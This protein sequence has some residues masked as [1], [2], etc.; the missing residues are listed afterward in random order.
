MIGSRTGPYHILSKIGEGGMGAVY[1]ARDERLGRDVA[2]KVFSPSAGTTETARLRLL[3]EA[4]LASALNHP[5]ICTIYGVEES[6]GQTLIVMEHVIGRRLL[7]VIPPEGLSVA[8]TLRYGAQIADALA[9][10]HGRNVLHRDLKTANVM[11]TAEDRVKVLDFGLAKR[12]EEGA[13]DAATRS[14]LSLTEPGSVVGTLYALAPEVLRGEAASVRSD[15]WALGVVLYEMAAGRPPFSGKTNFELSAAVLREEPSSLEATVP[16][17]LQ[18]VIARCFV[19]EPGRRYQSAAEVRAALEAAQ[20]STSLPIAPQQNSTKIALYLSI[21][22]FAVAASITIL[23]FARPKLHPPLVQYEQLTNFSDSVTSPAL[24]PDGRMLAFLHADSTFN[25]VGEIWVKALPDGEPA[26]VTNDGAH[27]MKPTFSPDGSRIAYSHIEQWNWDTWTV[28]SLGGKTAEKWLPNAS[29]LTWIG[30]QQVLFSEITTGLYMKIVTS[31]ENRGGEHDVYLPNSGEIAMAHSSTLS[32]DGKWVLVTEMDNRGW[33]PCRV[34]P[35]G[36]GP[37]V[38]VVGPSPS[39]CTSA[40][41]S[42]DG[43]SMYFSADNGQGFHLWR[44]EFP[45]GTV[46]QLTSGATEEEG[47]AVAHDGKSLITAIGTERS[48]IFLQDQGALRQITSQGYAYSPTLSPDGTQVY[49]LLRTAAERAFVAGDLRLVNTADGHESRLLPGFS[50]TRYDVSRDGQRIVFAA[51]GPDGKSNIWLAP[52]TRAFAPRQ[53]T[54]GEAYRPYFA[55]GGLIYY[56]R[57]EA[58][59]DYVFRMKED[60]TSQ[61]KVIGDPVIYL[62]A[63]SPDGKQLVTWEDRKQADSPNAVMVHAAA[64]GTEAVL[65]SRCFAT[66][67]SYA[68]AGIVSWSPDQKFLY[69]RMEL[70]GMPSRVT[71]V[72]P[73]A[74]GRA[75]PDLPASGYTSEQELRTI[76]GARIIAQTDVFPGRDPSTYVIM[77]ITTQRNLYRVRLP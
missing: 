75:L 15:I 34:A 42:P 40:A 35:F 2:V 3:R 49:Y 76:P 48:S 57:N 28:P 8:T 13:A 27:K 16:A 10:S 52:L 26:Q 11:I 4:Q 55:P 66:G 29:G 25:S 46:E 54:Q 5:N 61:E 45:D 72:I 47:I 77:K 41:W 50:V 74:S 23:L 56:L 32:P 69:L 70:P 59:K 1:L 22:V 31:D 33:L 71:T 6:G 62:L 39:K 30:K 9:H 37:Q 20:S 7:D 18:S 68:G 65:C 12:L 21:A 67:P 19:K 53:L 64:G 63:V 60:G 58:D 14:E 17:A 51:L 36:N 38:R 44:Q 43:N 24:S 73:L